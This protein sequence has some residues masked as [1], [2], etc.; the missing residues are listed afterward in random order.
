[1]KTGCC[2]GLAAAALMMAGI[3]TP[4]LAADSKAELLARKL[5]AVEAEMAALKAELQRMK[6][7]EAEQ[8]RQ[9]EAVATRVSTVESTA[10]E[11]V[12]Q[13]EQRVAKLE[14]S[15]PDRPGNMLFFRGG[16]PELSDD[17][18]FGSFTDTHLGGTGLGAGHNN[19]SGW[20]VGA[21]FDFLL[22]RN[23]WGLLPGTWVLAELGLEYK[24]LG[25]RD[26]VL[27][28]PTAECALVTGQVGGNIGNCLVT[29]NN[30]LTMFTIS[31]SPKIEL[32]EGG[33]LRPWIIPIGLD[34]HVISPPSDAATV[35]DVGGQVAVG[36]D[37]EIMPGI[38]V[39]ADF[40]YHFAADQTATNNNLV[41]RVNALAPGLLSGDT[42]KGNDFWTAG[43]YL[44]IG[45]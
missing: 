23:T 41:Q 43:G 15:R 8:S 40:R 45:F 17:R 33:A 42:N 25:S 44:G 3:T 19:D 31:A 14:T 21:G 26:T 22:T 4:A 38:K 20:Y 28:V 6:S 16:Y 39:G 27:V 34:M 24:H 32:L 10:N 11:P 36:A 35:F 18:S 12:K 7:D 1:M 2:A 30:E 9:V 37:Y 5:E 29:G 13:V